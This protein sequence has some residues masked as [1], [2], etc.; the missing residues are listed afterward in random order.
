MNPR[1]IVAA[2][3]AAT[4]GVIMTLATVSACGAGTPQSDDLQNVSPSY[5]DY[6]RLV[7]N[8]DGY[9]NIVMLC[10]HGQGFM[11]TQRV[12]S[13]SAAEPVDSWNSFC[14]QQEGKQATQNGQP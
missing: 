6:A 7:I 3:A 1:K 5:P 12:N 4:A 8:V 10:V 2:A 9:P 14:Q 11:T 13:P